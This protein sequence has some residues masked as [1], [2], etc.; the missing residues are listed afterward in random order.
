MARPITLPPPEAPPVVTPSTEVA[1]PSRYR[2]PTDVLRLIAGALVLSCLLAL[3]ALLPRQ[4]L[5][6][7][8]GVATWAGPG[9]EAGR[10]LV[11]LVHVAGACA[12][13]LV[14]VVLLGQRRFRLLATLAAGAVVA[15]VAMA[16]LDHLVGRTPPARLTANLDHRAWL[17]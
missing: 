2:R 1:Q 17:A 3:G 12:T 10:L 14:V 13:A 7:G 16:A 6:S 8:A 11:A 5:G 15:M 9:S 4:L